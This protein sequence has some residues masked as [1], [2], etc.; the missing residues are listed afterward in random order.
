MLSQHPSKT[1][2]WLDL[3]AHT[4]GD[5]EIVLF[6]QNLFDMFLKG[7]RLIGKVRSARFLTTDVA[8]MHVVGGMV[9]AGHAARRSTAGIAA[10][11]VPRFNVSDAWAIPAAAAPVPAIMA[12]ILFLEACP[13]LWPLMHIPNCVC[14]SYI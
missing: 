14:F 6:C 8:V 2:T 13:I 10:A 7:S 4:L 3:M 12:A 1:A 5:K 9:M 11:P